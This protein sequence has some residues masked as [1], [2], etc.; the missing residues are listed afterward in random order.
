MSSGES[1]LGVW[2]CTF[3]LC[4]IEWTIFKYRPSLPANA[5][6]IAI[7]G[8]SMI[9]HIFQAYRW[10]QWTFGTLF[11]L[12]CIAEMVGYGG[13]IIMHDNPWSF[14]GFMVQ[15]GERFREL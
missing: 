11:S 9:V 2:N 4:S 12:G 5:I 14:V 8:L 13:R 3:E 7:F 10:K 1:E 6:F 15:I